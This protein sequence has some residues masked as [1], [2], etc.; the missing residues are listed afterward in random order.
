MDAEG[1]TGSFDFIFLQIDLHTKLNCGH[2]LINFPLPDVAEAFC[3]NFTG[4]NQ[5][6]GPS[7]NACQIAWNDAL[8]GLDD[9]IAR[10]RNSPVMHKSIPDEYKPLLYYGSLRAPFPPA[11]KKIRAPRLHYQ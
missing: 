2:A 3:E 8:H 10:Y 11:T 1:Y 6:L 9:H 5:W 7:D 4:F